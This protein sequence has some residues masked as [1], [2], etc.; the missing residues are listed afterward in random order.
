MPTHGEFC[1]KRRNILKFRA[2]EKHTDD[3]KGLIL[4]LVPIFASFAAADNDVYIGFD[5]ITY[6]GRYRRHATTI[7]ERMIGLVLYDYDYISA[8]DYLNRC[9][10]HD[11][12]A[13]KKGDVYCSLQ[14]N[15][16][17]PYWEPRIMVMIHPT[18]IVGKNND[19][20]THGTYCVKF[21][22]E[23]S[24][25]GPI[26]R[27]A[28]RM[29][30]FSDNEPYCKIYYMSRTSRDMEW[31]GCY[32]CTSSEFLWPD[33]DHSYPPGFPWVTE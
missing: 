23:G 6:L 3:M 8:N 14:G 19:H 21:P 1:C 11:I 24:T 31:T 13:P 9:V 18:L 17:E 4:L 7:A 27:P 12:F 22:K 25:N 2:L 5:N 15:A 16:Q 33:Y 30:I 10:V 32:P 20:G 26:F 29:E 28:V